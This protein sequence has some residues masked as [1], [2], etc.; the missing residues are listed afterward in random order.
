MLASFFRS[1]PPVSSVLGRVRSTDSDSVFLLN[2]QTISPLP[3][4]DPC[5][6]ATAIWP[7]VLLF[8]DFE[9]FRS[10]RY[11]L[12]G[13]E[14]RTC[15][16][17]D[18]ARASRLVQRAGPCLCTGRSVAGPVAAPFMILSVISEGHCG[19]AASFC[20]CCLR[21]SPRPRHF[22]LCR[23]TSNRMMPERT[24]LPGRA[25]GSPSPEA[26]SP[27][28]T[29][30]CVWLARMPM[31]VWR[32]R[33]NAVTHELSHRRSVGWRTDVP[34]FKRV[35]IA[36]VYPG[37]DL[38][39]YNVERSLE[40]DFEIAPGGDP[41]RIGFDLDGASEIGIEDG[42]LRIAS[43]AGT[44]RWSR[45]VVYQK[46]SGG[47]REV[48]GRLRID[49]THVDFIVGGYDS[50]RPLVIDPVLSF[51]TYFGSIGNEA[52]RGIGTD[53][54]G[55]IYIA[56]VT[57]SR[58]LPVSANAA[59]PAYGGQTTQYQTGDAFVAKFSPAGSL[60]AMTYLGG[61]RD[62]LA[63]SLAVDASG[64]VFVTGYTNSTDFPF[65]ARAYQP[66]MAGAGGNTLFTIGDAFVV[67]LN[68]SLSQILYSTCI[69][70]LQDEAGIALAIDSAGNAYIAGITLSRDFPITAGAY[71]TFYRGAGGQPPTDFGTPFFITG[72]V[73]VSKLS[74]DGSQLL[75]STYLGGS[76]DDAATSIAVDPAGNVYVAGFTVSSNFPVTAGALQTTFRGVESENE[77]YNL[78]DGL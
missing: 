40:F 58:N 35:R 36:D 26:G 4:I 31:R 30:T 13:I 22:R 28:R 70:G 57:T 18:V 37:I 34:H 48:P 63:S 56:G 41:R 66:R 6:A 73:F 8:H 5:A 59:Q 53:A 9:Q 68:S 52:A 72:D 54:A 69:G 20:L 19:F 1:S 43:A 42:G 23:F 11:L 21:P 29:F 14:R 61:S 25:I 49:G 44:L 32:R 77:F 33:S 15:T 55:N 76:L 62:D 17:S 74:A 60:L 3:S 71:Q 46:G 39:V 45:P 24:P 38:V 2:S 64:N 51:S 10:L 78:G 12:F 27:S 75:F 47:R 65:S 7:P 16:N 67:K 50:S